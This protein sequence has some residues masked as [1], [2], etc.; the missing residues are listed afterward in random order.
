M[1]RC[2]FFAPMLTSARTWVNDPKLA[3]GGPLADIGVHCIDTLRFVLADE[4]R[5]VTARAQLRLA[6]G[7]GSVGR[8]G[9]GI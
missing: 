2:D 7:T 8:V 6:L 3:A 1:A 5:A 9:A 4:V